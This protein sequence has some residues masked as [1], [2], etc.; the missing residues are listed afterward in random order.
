MSKKKV[1]KELEVKTYEEWAKE[2]YENEKIEILD[3][4]G[5]RNNPQKT[6][7]KEE[8]NKRLLICTIQQRAKERV[9]TNIKKLKCNY[10][11]YKEQ[12]TQHNMPVEEVCSKCGKSFEAGEEIY[13]EFEEGKQGSCI[14][15]VN[16]AKGED[17]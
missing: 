12:R 2:L 10:T 14:I 8:F 5:F 16:C 11:T 4:D 3:P 9:F 7:T 13:T 15:C 1:K 17:E 6:Y